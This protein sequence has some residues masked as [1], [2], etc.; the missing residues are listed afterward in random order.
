MMDGVVL[1]VSLSLIKRIADRDLT[2]N[3]ALKDL[4]RIELV[5]VR[6]GNAPL[7]FAG[8]KDS[9]PVLCAVVGALPV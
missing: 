1:M 5:Y 3:R 8:A 9:R 4:S 7:V 2:Y 6:L